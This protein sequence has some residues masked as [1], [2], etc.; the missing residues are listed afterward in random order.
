MLFWTIVKVATKSLLSNKLRSI[1]AMLG[2][3][4]GV[5]AVIS[6]LA[7]GAGAQKRVMDR[8]SSMG[9]NL[10]IVR[11][12]QGGHRGVRTAA[13][14]NLTL[15]DALAVLEEVPTVEI[16]APVV[17]GS[18]QLKY[19]NNNS[20]LSV[21][22]TSITYFPIRNFEVERGRPFTE[23]EVERSA[24]VVV[25][26]PTTVENLFEN[27]D[28]LEETVKIDG[29]NFKV[30][31]V[32][33]A[34][35]DQGWFNP[36]DQAIIPYTTAMKQL[37]GVNY[38]REIDLQAVEGADH[39]QVET[40]ASGVLRRRHRIQ[41]EADDDFHIRNLAEM[42]EAASDVTQTF[43]ILLG[44]VAGISLLVGGIG[45]MN[46][47]LVTVT[48]RTREIG[49]RKAIGAKDRDILTQFLLEAI[50]MSGLGGLLGV[51]VGVGGAKA[52]ANLSEFGTVIT[53]SSV[54]LA[55]SFSAAVGI[56]FGF[57]PARRAALL[58]P[59][60]ALRYE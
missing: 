39:T 14:Q 47:M 42:A 37:L 21:T 49:V 28:P 16:I 29:I 8:I 43:T 41:S 13:G 1:L 40:Q 4:I 34:K 7:L 20:R 50:V 22:G 10:L 6:M 60:E 11:P 58:D 46:I 17:Q 30:V 48:E 27:S 57:Y 31:G 54:V 52:I 44:A 53:A 36:D 25:L 19:Y 32:L 56:F 2:I 12:G 5:A 59:I 24:R 33:K 26:G 51:L 38:L 9:A 3:I 45:I 35:G 15:N 55:L 23:S 18:A